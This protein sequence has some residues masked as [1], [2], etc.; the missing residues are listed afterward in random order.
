MSYKLPPPEQL[1]MMC[2]GPNPYGEED[3]DFCGY[4][5]EIYDGCAGAY[6]EEDLRKER[7]K[8]AGK[9]EIIH[10][11]ERFVV[12]KLESEPSDANFV[13][14]DTSVEVDNDELE[15]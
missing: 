2:G 11:T 14:P 1:Y 12:M 7:A 13:P 3:E 15:G 9:G 5:Q 8:E 4:G 10:E 6:N